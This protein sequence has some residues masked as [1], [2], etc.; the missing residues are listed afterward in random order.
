MTAGIFAFTPV[1]KVRLTPEEFRKEYMIPKRPVVLTGVMEQWPGLNWSID[2][3]G[4]RFGDDTLPV[5]QFEEDS[6]WGAHR[7]SEQKLSDFLSTVM[8]APWK[9]TGRAPLIDSSAFFERYPELREDVPLWSYFDNWIARL[10][11]ELRARH[12]N[13]SHGWILIGPERAVYNLHYDYWSAHA[14]IVQFEGR[15][16]V[17]LYPPDQ[18]APLYSGR[19]DVDNPDL[20]KFPEFPYAQGRMEAILEPGDIAFVPSRWWHQVGYLTP[21]LSLNSFIVNTSNVEDYLADLELYREMVESVEAGVISD[22][23]EHIREFKE[24]PPST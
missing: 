16:R 12:E 3:L 15:K 23:I 22:L 1:D 19:V 21:C 13:L 2:Y 6:Q 20:A 10:P 18:R 8:S 5:R 14:C 7:V 9:G 11:P 24:T 4:R 17:V